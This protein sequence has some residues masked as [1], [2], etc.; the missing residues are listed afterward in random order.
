MRSSLIAALAGLALLLPAAAAAGSFGSPDVAALQVGLTGRALYDGDVDGFA[1]PQT[2]AGLRRLPGATTPLA[3]ETRAALGTF[4]AVP[5]GGRP[6]VAGYAGW[7]VAALQFMLAWHGFPSGAFDGA[8]GDRTVAALIRFQRWAGIDPIGV[9]G[10]MTL[11]ALRAPPPVSPIH[12]MR[13]IDAAPTD[14]F[15]PRGERFHTGVDYPAA[16]GAPVVAAGDG[17]VVSTGIVTGYGN[18][19]VVQHSAGV[20]TF[21]AHLSKILVE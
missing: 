7:D 16:M 18:L 13:P 20:T 19:V 9:A 6:L 4:G 21:Y 15:G 11:T 12:L 2:L 1:G 10:P 5:L 17:T 3:P 14:G 8:L